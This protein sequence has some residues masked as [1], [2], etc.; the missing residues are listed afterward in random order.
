M[1]E[2]H[3]VQNHISQQVNLIDN[4][5]GT[6]PT[7]E[8][9][10]QATVQLENEVRSWYSS[11]CN[12]LRSQ[13]EYMHALNQWIRLTDCLPDSNDQTGSAIGIRL[14]GEEWQLALDRLPD[15]VLSFVI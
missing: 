3:Q 10:R 15:K 12:L 7:T 5:P 13:R 6:E 4:Q 14:L 2:C 11:F 9:H 8:M 1:Y